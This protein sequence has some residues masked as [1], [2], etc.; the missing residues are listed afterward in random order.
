M[1][2]ADMSAALLSPPALARYV[3]ALVQSPQV[4]PFIMSKLALTQRL[5]HSLPR[6]FSMLS[7]FLRTT[8]MAVCDLSPVAK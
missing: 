1:Y 2:T 5:K 4:L 3:I 8:R 7:Q 6:R